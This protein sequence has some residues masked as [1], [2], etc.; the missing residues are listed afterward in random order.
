[1][2]AQL[3]DCLVP[4][5]NQLLPPLGKGTDDL[6]GI[7]PLRLERG[8]SESGRQFTSEGGTHEMW[9]LVFGLAHYH[10]DRALSSSQ[11]TLSFCLVC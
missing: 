9:I 11:T 5:W 10:H 4:I 3:V 8:D 7:A 6:E 2:V 1:M